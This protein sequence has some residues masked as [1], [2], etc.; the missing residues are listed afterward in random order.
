[1]WDPV[2]AALGAEFQVHTPDLPGH[3]ARAGEP[4]RMAAAVAMVREV[5]EAVAPAPVVLGGDSLGSYVAL[6]SAP[7]LGDRL[8][9]LVLAGYGELPGSG[10]AFV[11]GPDRAHSPRS[12]GDAP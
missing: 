5:V 10:G 6:A 9:G 3:G 4:F 11:S 8:R 7:N 2:V 1:M 12:A